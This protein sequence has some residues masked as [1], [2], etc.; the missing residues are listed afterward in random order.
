MG[1]FFTGPI[2]TVDQKLLNI[3]RDIGGRLGFGGQYA[4]SSGAGT[5]ND[6]SQGQGSFN[7]NMNGGTAAGGYA[8]IG[9]YDPLETDFFYGASSI[10]YSRRIR[11]AFQGMMYIGSTNS[12][13]RVVFGGTGNSTAAPAADANG[14]TVKG[15]GVEFFVV[16]GLVQARLIGFNGSYL[17]PTSYTTLTNGFASVAN[18][19]RYFACMI[20]SDGTGNINL[21]GANS[22][23]VRN[24][25]ISPTPL[26]TLTGGPT[27]STSSNRFGPE[28]QLVNNST[29]APTAGSQ[30]V[31][32]KLLTND[33]WLLDVQ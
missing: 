6:A 13:I 17:T 21:Y 28:I 24:I 19:N 32:L 23:T 22:S 31:A 14:L 15:F 10:D 2:S 9:Y 4:L 8:K 33:N 7:I 3:G 1:N 20:E 27:N 29:V 12:R 30:S 25:S 5:T 16:S 11:F 18:S 26:L